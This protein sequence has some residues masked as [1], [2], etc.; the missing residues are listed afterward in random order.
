MNY[1]KYCIYKSSAGKD[2]FGKRKVNQDVYLVKINM[3][4]I[5]GFN[6]FGVLDGHGENGHLVS[7]FARNF[8]IE[9]IQNKIKKSNKK[10]L[11]EIYSL[12]IKDNYSLIKKAYQK[13]R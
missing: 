10:S 1:F 9:E 13:G 12:L 5:E 4:D 2:S 7:R 11:S 8:I 6:L 3:Y